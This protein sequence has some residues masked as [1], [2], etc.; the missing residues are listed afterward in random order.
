M[1]ASRAQR[2]IL[3]YYEGLSSPADEVERLRKKFVYWVRHLAGITGSSEGNPLYME[4]ENSSSFHP[5]R[6]GY[7]DK[8]S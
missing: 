6:G 4:Q 5:A 7:Y 2:F 3:Y 8:H 1:T